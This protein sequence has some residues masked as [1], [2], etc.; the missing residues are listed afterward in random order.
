MA[1]SVLCLFY[2]IYPLSGT[3]SFYLMIKHLKKCVFSLAGVPSSKNFDI[4]LMM[5]L[6]KNLKQVPPQSLK[7]NLVPPSSDKS[8]GADLV[9]LRLH[10]N[11]I[12]HIESNTIDAHIFK[13]MWADITQVFCSLYIKKYPFSFRKR[14][15][16]VL[17]VSFK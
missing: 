3:C 13:T 12:G 14:R 6:L 17:L 2:V 7:M 10:R 1:R 9:R 8:E 5:C 16:L 11:T 4:T 15:Q